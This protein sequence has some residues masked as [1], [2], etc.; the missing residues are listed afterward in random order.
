MRQTTASP[1]PPQAPPQ[2]L[3]G[4]RPWCRRQARRSIASFREVLINREAIWFWTF[5]NTYYAISKSR[6]KGL[7]KIYSGVIDVSDTW[8]E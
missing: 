5:Q 3:F 1:Q 6:L 7:P 2:R 8:L 4:N